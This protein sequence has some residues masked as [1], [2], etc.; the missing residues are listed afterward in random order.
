LH[1]RYPI[2]DYGSPLVEQQPKYPT[3]NDP[4]NGSVVSVSA[5]H[6]TRPMPKKMVGSQSITV[7]EEAQTGDEN[8]VSTILSVFDS[9]GFNEKELND[10]KSNQSFFLR[11]VAVFE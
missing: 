4:L 1:Q 8:T 9:K 7:I 2:P 5:S 11:I 6:S 10:K 3:P